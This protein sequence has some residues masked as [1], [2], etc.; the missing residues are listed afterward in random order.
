VGVIDKPNTASTST[1]SD[2]EVATPR[3]ETLGH[4]NGA[5]SVVIHVS[6]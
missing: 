6:R 2:H 3:A 1:P 4:P 5:D